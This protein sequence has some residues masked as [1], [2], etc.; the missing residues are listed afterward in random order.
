ML[1]SIVTNKGSFYNIF[2]FCF[3]YLFCFANAQ[4]FFQREVLVRDRL[5]CFFADVAKMPWLIHITGDFFFLFGIVQD[6]TVFGT[7]PAKPLIFRCIF[8]LSV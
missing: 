1:W 2:L 8:L 4:I 5:C 6:K 3:D 7:M